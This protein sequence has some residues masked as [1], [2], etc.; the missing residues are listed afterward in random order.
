MIEKNN[1]NTKLELGKKIKKM[2]L[3]LG[4]SQKDLGDVLHIKY[5]TVCSWEKGHTAPK[6]SKIK[7][8]AKFFNVTIDYLLGIE[9]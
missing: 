1:T 3:S 5:S 4:L 9:D 7:Q 6:I 2:R 8:L